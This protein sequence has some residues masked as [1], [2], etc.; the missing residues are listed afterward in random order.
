MNETYQKLFS[1]KKNAG[2]TL[3]EL[4]VVVLI[5]GILS[6]VALPQYQKAV[7]KSRA[8][9]AVQLLRYMH[10]Q[11]ELCILAN[12]EQACNQVRNEEAGI[13]LGAGFEC[14][15]NGDEE[16]CC[17]KDWCY[18][19]GSLSWGY[20]CATGLVNGPIARRRE[21]NLSIDEALKYTL[22][23]ET[24]ESAPYKGQI[25]CYDS[26]KWCKLFHGEGKPI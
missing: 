25:V 3:I 14:T 11:G 13:E 5:I 12:G 17:N 19:N 9:E 8:A 26:E 18:A 22:Q 2:F 21:G 20:Y 7:E 24:C 6:A 23:Y 1:G 15:F 4:L 16:V 10:Q